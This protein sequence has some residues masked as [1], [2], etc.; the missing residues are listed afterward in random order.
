MVFCR[1]RRQTD[2]RHGSAYPRAPRVL[3]HS[4]T[5]ILLL[6]GE[7]KKRYVYLVNGFIE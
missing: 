4:V 2:A 5:L 6:A 7:T 3:W 1:L